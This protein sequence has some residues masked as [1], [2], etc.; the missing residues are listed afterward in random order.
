MNEQISILVIDD[1]ITIRTLIKSAFSGE[2]FQVNTAGNGSEGLDIAK[3]K[4]ID[5]VL[6]DWL[7]PDMDGI[8]VL[9][10]LKRDSKTMFIPVVM[11]TGKEDTKDFELA[12]SRGAADYIRKPFNLSEVPAMIRNYLQKNGFPAHCRRDSLLNRFFAHNK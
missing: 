10:E 12:M 9:A 11:L 4:D 7:M 1:D 8:E 2:G 3:H 5:V 6:L